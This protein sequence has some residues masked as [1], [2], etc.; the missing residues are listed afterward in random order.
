MAVEGGRGS[1]VMAAG[2]KTQIAGDA[3]V[4]GMAGWVVAKTSVGQGH[5]QLDLLW[6]HRAGGGTPS[7][8]GLGRAGS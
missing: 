5:V 6:V 8:A 2:Y 7:Q 4:Q 3:Q 1:V